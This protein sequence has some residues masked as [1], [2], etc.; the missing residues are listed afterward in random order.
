MVLNWAGAVFF[1][2]QRNI[3]HSSV[4]HLFLKE[5]MTNLGNVFKSRDITLVSKGCIVNSYGFSSSHVQ[6]WELDHKEG[7]APKNWCF[8]NLVLG[9]DS[10]EPLGQQG[11]QNSQSQSKSSLNI[12]WKDWCW[13]WSP[14]TLAT[15]WEEPTHWKRPWCWERLKSEEEVGSRGWDG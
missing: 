13:S 1:S 7:W 12:H 14:D 11:D 2:K 15:W 10:W 5:A 6:M 9:E 8:Q 4:Y 3:F